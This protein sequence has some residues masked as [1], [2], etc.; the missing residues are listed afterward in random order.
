MNRDN[1]IKQWKLFCDSI[2]FPTPE[3]K[4]N[5]LNNLEDLV[6][7][8]LALLNIKGESIPSEYYSLLELLL[9]EDIY[10]RLVSLYSME[11]NFSTEYT[12][13]E[14][15]QI[16]TNYNKLLLDVKDEIASMSNSSVFRVAE[17]GNR[18][19]TKK[20]STQRGYDLSLAQEVG[21][22]F[23]VGLNSIDLDWN[24]FDLSIGRFS[25]YTIYYS[26]KVIY[27]EYL[28]KP[29]IF[30]ADTKKIVI[31]DINK[32][33]LRLVDLLSDTEYNILVQINQTSKASSLESFKVKTNA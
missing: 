6:D 7:L 13:I 3:Y 10:S 33:K 30:D 24:R 5:Y 12:A 21:S 19:S 28:L 23:K 31:S 26:T 14:R 1:L 8:K 17:I 18:I 22:T 4:E 20:W 15:N 32:T 11:Y 27:D 29:Y 25:N 16:F 9:K 2:P